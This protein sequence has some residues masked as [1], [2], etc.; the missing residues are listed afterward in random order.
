MSSTFFSLVLNASSH[1][2]PQWKA[3]LGQVN[4]LEQATVGCYRLRIALV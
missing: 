4:S 2:Q 1:G 3:S